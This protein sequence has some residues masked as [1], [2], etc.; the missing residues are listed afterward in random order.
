MRSE[1][2]RYDTPRQLVHSQHRFDEYT[3]DGTLERSS[4][5]DLRLAYL[6]PPDL[7]RLLTRAGF[8]SIQI[9]G[10]FDG[11]PFENDTDELVIEAS[12]E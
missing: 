5:H 1:A 6:Y 4:L 7:R 9:Y 11:R 8:R 3:A 2:N 10:G 12:V